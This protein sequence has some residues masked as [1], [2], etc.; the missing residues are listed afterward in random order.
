MIFGGSISQ[1]SLFKAESLEKQDVPNFGKRADTRGGLSKGLG[2]FRIGRPLALNN[3]KPG[4]SF[5]ASLVFFRV[6]APRFLSGCPVFSVPANRW[7]RTAKSE[8]AGWRWPLRWD[9]PEGVR[10]CA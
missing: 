3:K 4:S 5:R 6:F 2:A 10:E 8:A 1:R 7:S 9:V